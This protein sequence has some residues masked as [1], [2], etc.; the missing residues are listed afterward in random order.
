MKKLIYR[1]T[2]ALWGEN[3]FEKILPI[4]VKLN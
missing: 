4:M 1:K 2:Y 3:I